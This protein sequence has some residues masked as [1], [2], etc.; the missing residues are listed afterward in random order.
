MRAVL[1]PKAE[2]ARTSLAIPDRRR[3]NAA[4]RLIAANPEWGDSAG[5][6][7]LNPGHGS[8]S[9]LIA[10]LVQMA[11]G[12]IVAITYRVRSAEQLVWIEDIRE[13]FVG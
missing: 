3:V 7:V 8:N 10:H 5:I 13:I 6:R 1:S 2:S 4:I 12:R 11:R 9:G